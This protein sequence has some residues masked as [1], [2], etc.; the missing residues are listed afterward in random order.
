MDT[1][2]PLAPA[3]P[4]PAPAAPAGSSPDR[5]APPGALGIARG[6]AL[7]VASVLGTG[8][9]ALPGLA[10]R[11]AGPASVLAVA[12]VLVASVPLAGTFA[13]LAARHPDRGGVASA[14][15]SA[16]GPT[17]ARATG[18]W[19]FLG[20]CVGV[21]VVAVLGAEYVVAVVGADRAAVPV[22]AVAL[23]VVPAVAVWLGVRVAGAVQLGLTSLLL[24]AVV[25]VVAVAAPAASAERF[26]PFLSEGW[27]GVGSAVS[28]F[29]WAFAGWEV[30]TH[31]SADFRDPRRTIPAATGVA[32]V[33]VGVAYLALQ[34]TTVG[35]LGTEAGSG[36][37]ALLD[38]ARTGAPAA[39]P[40]VVGVVAAIVTSGVLTAY[41][42]AF[43]N[44]GQ[45]LARDGDLPRALAALSGRAGVPRRALAV[46][47]VLSATYLA[48]LVGTGLD[49]EPF[50]RVH[51]SSMVAVYALGMV[52]ALRLLPR[53]SAGW[54][55]AAVATALTGVL[56]VLA[57][58]S[59]VA[60]GVLAL[61]AIG[62]AVAKRRP[63]P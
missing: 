56:L 58:A 61:A 31:V 12:L 54:W 15:R 51:T 33:V 11:V 34:V 29:V 5:H 40:V 35:V 39:G 32:L 36:T 41:L 55:L 59:L 28:L 30:G 9:L 8:V 14:V 1:P 57:G 22:V 10:T 6:S 18:Y 43:A 25:V 53:R 48:V 52:A 24:A 17:A 45:A 20:V 42:A 4:A 47:L 50:V 16:L 21:P 46:T 13:A 19:F 3:R 62:V 49:L 60:P 23:V 7:Y 44:L 2:T 38:L 37:V 63:T 26:T 27:S